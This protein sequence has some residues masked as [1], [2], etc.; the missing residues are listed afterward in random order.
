M[1]KFLK[2]A[3]Y[4]SFALVLQ[5][6]LF[7]NLHFGQN[8]LLIITKVGLI[9]AFFEIFLKPIVKILL[10][11]ISIL[12]LGLIRIVINTLGLYLASSLVSA[13]S[14]SS[15]TIY[16]WSLVGFWAYLGTSFF[17]SVFLYFFKII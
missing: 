12:T 15:F 7:G 14:V 4:L 3:L 8:R 11:P 17:I 10:L 13:F 1:K 16:G 6:E 2:Y 9:L 5:Q